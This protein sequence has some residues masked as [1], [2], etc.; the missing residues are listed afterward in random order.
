[1]TN[2]NYISFN[3]EQAEEELTVPHFIL[4]ITVCL[5]VVGII[6][7]FFVMFL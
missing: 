3:D 4:N 6:V 5:W 1:M 2:Q 7:V